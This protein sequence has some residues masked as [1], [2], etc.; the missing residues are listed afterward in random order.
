M[1]HLSKALS[2]AMVTLTLIATQPAQ[3]GKIEDVKAAVQAACKKELLSGE[4]SGA[5]LA[6]YD[7]Q[8]GS[9]VKVADCPIECQKTGGNVVG[10][11]K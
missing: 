2:L 10:G 8:P 5:V 11:G 6:A 9:T 4:L 1:H 3:A 7:C